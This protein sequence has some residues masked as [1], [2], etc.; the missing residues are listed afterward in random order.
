MA[1]SI[2]FLDIFLAELRKLREK[3]THFKARIKSANE[4]ARECDEEARKQN[5]ALKERIVSLENQLKQSKEAIEVTA[6]IIVESL[7]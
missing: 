1:P 2:D 5:T 7:S 6:A 3:H 4:A